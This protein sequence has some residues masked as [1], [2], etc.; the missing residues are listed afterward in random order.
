MLHFFQRI[1]GES[2][3]ASGVRYHCPSPYERNEIAHL[4]M[5]EIALSQ[6][7]SGNSEVFL[8]ASAACTN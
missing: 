4:E 5:M 1:R 3:L 6:N 8:D 2:E 7:G